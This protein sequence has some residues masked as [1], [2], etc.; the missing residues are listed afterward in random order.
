MMNQT[1]YLKRKAIAEEKSNIKYIDVE[2]IEGSLRSCSVVKTM[3][4]L[5]S[6]DD[7]R[8]ILIDKM[9]YDDGES[10]HISSENMYVRANYKIKKNSVLSDLIKMGMIVTGRNIMIDG[11]EYTKYGFYR[12]LR[13]YRPYDENG[14]A[15]EE[16]EEEEMMNENDCLKFAE[17]ISAGHY[18]NSKKLFNNMIKIVPELGEGTEP[19]LFAKNTK[20]KNDVFGM[21]DQ[22]NSTILKKTPDGKKNDMAVPKQGESY[23]IVRKRL[24]KTQ[25]KNPYH[26]AFVV[27]DKNK[28]NI[29]VEGFTGMHDKYRPRF[30]FYDTKKSGR[31]FH[32]VWTGSFKSPNKVVDM[33]F[34]DKSETIVLKPRK[35]IDSV[36]KY[37]YMDEYNFAVIG[38]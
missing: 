18:Y 8:S 12:R 25:A 28:V 30:C 29:T 22:N 7:E 17:C 36:M 3:A 6:L 32:R 14:T 11:E 24:S 26:I 20:H 16:D 21:S 19:V 2:M 13:D 31:T 10:I 27:Y 34:F 37:H 33:G 5:C 23:A 9:V 1:D 38:I 4:T 15:L 35:D